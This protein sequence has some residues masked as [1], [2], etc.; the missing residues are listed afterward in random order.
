LTDLEEVVDEY[1]LGSHHAHRHRRVGWH[2]LF[3]LNLSSVKLKLKFLVKVMFN[4]SYVWH[5]T[6]TEVVYFMRKVKLMA[7][8]KKFL[9][10]VRV[11]M[12]TNMEVSR[13]FVDENEA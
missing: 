11:V 9:D 10:R 5:A 12:S 2:V 4:M 3:L 7:T 1:A 13:H 8:H 6:E